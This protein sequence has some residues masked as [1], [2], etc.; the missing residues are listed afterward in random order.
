MKAAVVLVK[1]KDSEFKVKPDNTVDRRYSDRHWQQMKLNT[2][3]VH[4]S[5]SSGAQTHFHS[6][7]FSDYSM[8]HLNQ[9][10]EKAEVIAGRMLPFSVFYRNQ[11][12][13]YFDH[14]R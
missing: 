12:K 14:V 2:T 7:C 4:F 6:D 9:L 11:N 1:E 13:E 5:R 3:F 10:L 8:V